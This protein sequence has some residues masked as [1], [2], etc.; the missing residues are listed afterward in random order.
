MIDTSF[1]AHDSL[2]SALS[3]LY[4]FFNGELV[5]RPDQPG[6]LSFDDIEDFQSYEPLYVGA[7][8]NQAYY[9]VELVSVPAD[10]ETVH[11]WELLNVESFLF[12]IAGRALQLVTWHKTHQFCG[13]CGAKTIQSVTDWSCACLVCEQS[14]YPR[15][16][17]CVIM[18]IRKGNK[19]LLAQRPGSKHQMYSVLAGFIEPGE[20]AEQTVVR[21]VTE[22]VGIEIKNVRYF[23]SQPWPF[24]GQLMLGFMADYASGELTPDLT[25]IQDPRWFDYQDLP[26]Y[27]STNTISGRLITQTIAEI[28]AEVAAGTYS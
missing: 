11:L 4:A 26:E 21:E 20:T 28:A 18:S 9:A 14:F 12:D 6:P 19:I 13:S 17:P 24:P 7:H 5:V 10:F 2:D 3:P 27:P 8:K 1:R 15:L 23:A 22:E 16:S 25:E